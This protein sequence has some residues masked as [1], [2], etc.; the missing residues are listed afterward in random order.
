LNNIDIVCVGPLTCDYHINENKK[1]GLGNPGGG[2]LY[3]AVGAKLWNKKVG[4]VARIGD[5]YPNRWLRKFKS[6][7][8]NIE[9]VSYGKEIPLERVFGQYNKEGNREKFNPIQKFKELGI[10]I[11]EELKNYQIPENYV[12]LVNKVSPTPDDLPK[13]YEKANFF[14]L[15]PMPFKTQKKWVEKL[16]S[17]K[18][19]PIITLDPGPHYMG[20]VAFDKIKNLLKNVDVFL[21][22]EKEIKKCFPGHTLIEAAKIIKEK[23]IKNLVIKVGGQGSLLFGE[24]NRMVHIPIV[25]AKPVDLTGAGD[26]YCGGLLAS[27]NEGNNILTATEYGSVSS[28]FV[29]EGFGA[30]PTLDI[31]Y[32]DVLERFKKDLNKKINLY[33]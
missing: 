13:S 17:L 23:K 12:D 19:S 10:E 11:P 29:I 6:Y 31:K 32:E 28:S 9:G 33:I 14:H 16:K 2:A 21:P 15:A 30:L 20:E 24:N 1:V 18:S 7:G 27:L 8:L 4:I 25:D 3:S 5:E 22:S 26:S